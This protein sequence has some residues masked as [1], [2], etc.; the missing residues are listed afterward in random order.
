MKRVIFM[1]ALALGAYGVT[2]A[3]KAKV[4][5][6]KNSVIINQFDDAKKNMDEALADPKS[7]E[8]PETFITAAYVYGKLAA[9]GKDNDGITKAK[10]F[11]EKANQLDKEAKKPGKFE[12]K[13]LK[14]MPE[15]SQDAENFAIKCFNE[16]NYAGSRDAFKTAIWAHQNQENPNGY[17]ELADSSWILNVGLASMQ[18][19]DWNTG[20]EYFLKAGNLGV[21]GQ[22][23]FLR[24]N[25][26]YEQL[27]DSA[28]IEK[29][30]K[31]GFVKYPGSKDIVNSL[32]NYYLKAGKNAEAL[33]YLNDALAK[34]PKNAQY[35][36]AKGCLNEKLEPE[37][38]IRD[39]K[40]AVS[41]DP[42]MFYPTFNLGIVYYNQSMAKRNE[43]S[44]T[45]DRAKAKEYEIE[46]K[47]IMEN[48]VKYMEKAM[49]IADT[50][51]NR[52]LAKN[53]LRTCYNSLASIN[54]SLGNEA[55]YEKYAAK[56]SALPR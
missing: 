32:I 1:V 27:K 54:Y 24:A 25:Y 5:R 19:E 47:N 48:A 7:A 40:Q 34:D 22:M 49:A 53:N 28:N 29:T 52:E 2:Y 30:L 43:S 38:A 17:N 18:A 13:I 23:S 56:A 10:Q 31:T 3:Q 37:Q 51:D 36:F 42:K 33:E 14:A 45:R 35:H 21:D 8:D 12:K 55:E 9:A 46:S 11:L 39:Y 6:A 44:S 16:K 20:A 4:T 50:E 15:L 26:C 41:L